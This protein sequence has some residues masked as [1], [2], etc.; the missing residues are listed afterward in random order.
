[1]DKPLGSPLERRKKKPDPKE[2]D[3]ALHLYREKGEVCPRGLRQEGKRRESPATGLGR[4]TG[5][6]KK[7]K[8]K[9]D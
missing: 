3:E 5:H 9:G 8:K 6:K 1:M 2:K 7:K 4:S